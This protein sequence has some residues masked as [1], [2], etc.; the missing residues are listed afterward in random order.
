MLTSAPN[1]MNRKAPANRMGQWD[2]GGMWMD[3]G[4]RAGVGT[5]VRRGAPWPSPYFCTQNS[6]RSCTTGT[7]AKLYTGGGEGMVHSSVRPSHGSAGAGAAERVVM[8]T[9][10]R[11]TRNESTITSEPI[12]AT[13][14]QKF[15]PRSG[16]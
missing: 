6:S 9:F 12:V 3:C 2:G 11:K 10:Q 1:I 8:I 14:F 16:A 13:M 15:Q 7:T 5:R 4:S